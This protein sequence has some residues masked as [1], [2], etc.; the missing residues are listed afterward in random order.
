MSKA[1]PLSSELTPEAGKKLDA[2]CNRFEAACRGSVL[3]RIE[4][5]LR[6]IPDGLSPTVLLC[7]LI[8][9]DVHYRRMKGEIP[10]FDDY[11]KRFLDIETTWL[12]ELLP[13][14]GL[15]K[16]KGDLEDIVQSALKSFF[17]RCGQG[18]FQ[19][20]SRSALWALLVRVT[21]HKCG[22]RA[23]YAFAEKR[24]V[25]NEAE[26]QAPQ[27]FS[28]AEIEGLARDPSPDEVAILAETVEQLLQG[29]ELHQQKIVRLRLEGKSS[30]DIAA[31]VGI[32]QKSV[33]R[34]LRG[35]RDRLENWVAVEKS[36]DEASRP[37][38]G[39]NK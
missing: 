32:S 15:N 17:Q 26:C 22:H 21:L 23:E 30:A 38:V 2:I 11:E 7:E 27:E 5:F 35:V 9:L 19:L 34:V 13:P 25:A 28:V 14:Q 1:Q 12:K 39:P 10:R 8:H 31:L 16:R 6:K 29:L 24:N 18:Q 4:D 37:S 36:P 33:Q 3:P 20:K